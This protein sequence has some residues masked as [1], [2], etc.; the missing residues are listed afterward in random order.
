MVAM[1]RAE[2][3]KNDNIEFDIF[4]QMINANIS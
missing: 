2:I 3:F 4:D 1:L